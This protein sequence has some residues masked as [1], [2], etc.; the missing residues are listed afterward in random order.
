MFGGI[1]VDA[2]V[3]GGGRSGK[4]TLAHPLKSRHAVG[5]RDLTVTPLQRR[6]TVGV[7]L[8]QC[9]ACWAAEP[10]CDNDDALAGNRVIATRTLDRLA[11]LTARR[12][13]TVERAWEE[14]ASSRGWP[15]AKAREVL[16]LMYF[17]KEY[18]AFDAQQAPLRKTLHELREFGR[19]LA[20]VPPAGCDFRGMV[21]ELARQ[22]GA[23]EDEQQRW[24]LH[25]LEA[26]E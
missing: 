2:V 4:Q 8:A 19:S 1:D 16:A 5:S 26:T 22:L 23:M 20:T 15:S 13:Q 7:C 6:L 11:S 10:P 25:K 12:E 24:A 17:G 18:R 14:R 9:L 21:D 3:T